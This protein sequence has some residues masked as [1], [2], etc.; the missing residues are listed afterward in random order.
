M[1]WEPYISCLPSSRCTSGMNLV[2]KKIAREGNVKD[3]PK[4]GEGVFCHNN[5]YMAALF[6]SIDWGKNL[7]IQYAADLSKLPTNVML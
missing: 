3:F 5:L 7:N 2:L 6:L 1:Y 4:R